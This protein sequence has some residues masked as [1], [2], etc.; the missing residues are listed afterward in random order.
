MNLYILNANWKYWVVCA[1]YCTG[2]HKEHASVMYVTIHSDTTSLFIMA[3][4]KQN[5]YSC[6]QALT[7]TSKEFGNINILYY[8]PSQHWILITICIKRNPN[9]GNASG[10][11]SQ[12]VQIKTTFI[13]IYKHAYIYI[14]WAKIDNKLWS[15]VIHSF[16]Q[17]TITFSLSLSHFLSLTLPLSRPNRFLSATWS[18]YPKI[19]SSP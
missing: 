18:P 11:M 15:F 4:L 6:L 2:C 12:C 14:V 19:W 3:I 1:T 9:K 16:H 17:F 7:E 8:S 10:H 5:I 13:D